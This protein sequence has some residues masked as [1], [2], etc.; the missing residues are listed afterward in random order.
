MAADPSQSEPLGTTNPFTYNV[1][2]SGFVGHKPSTRVAHLFAGC[3]GERLREKLLLP[4][5]RLALRG[6]HGTT[7]PVIDA[8]QTS[9]RLVCERLSRAGPS[10]PGV[11]ERHNAEQC[12]VSVALRS[13]DARTAQE[14]WLTSSPAP[15]PAC[16]AASSVGGG[17]AASCACTCFASLPNFCS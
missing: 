12:V 2:R 4:S 5:L 3:P 14:G 17:A 16:G 10:L 15:P 11:G 13:A 7:Q 6:G 1:A 8:Y 9:P